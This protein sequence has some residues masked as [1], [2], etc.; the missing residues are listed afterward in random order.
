MFDG[1]STH[2]IGSDERRKELSEVYKDAMTYC[3]KLELL[4]G[5][6]DVKTL[7]MVFLG[8]HV[9]HWSTSEEA[10]ALF[11]PLFYHSLAVNTFKGM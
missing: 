10:Q 6:C 7:S 9:V 4:P 3:N 1:L 2:R 8:Q 11:L 5:V